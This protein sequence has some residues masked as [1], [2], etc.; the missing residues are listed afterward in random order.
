MQR[1]IR[2]TT[3]HGSMAFFGYQFRTLNQKP[4]PRWN[5]KFPSLP[6][7]IELPYPPF[8]PS[9]HWG[10][11]RHHIHQ[12][13][14]SAAAA[15]PTFN[16]F[17]WINYGVFHWIVRLHASPTPFSDIHRINWVIFINPCGVHDKSIEYFSHCCARERKKKEFHSWHGQKAHSIHC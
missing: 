10:D 9:S 2:R 7:T 13:A 3:P 11:T 16:A 17:S 5:C 14:L 8:S 6:D 1:S 4:P 15:L 12:P